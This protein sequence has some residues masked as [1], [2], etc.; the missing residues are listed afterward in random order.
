VCSTGVIT[1]LFTRK[2]GWQYGSHW[3]RGRSWWSSVLVTLIVIHVTVTTKYTSG[4]LGKSV[5]EQ[6]LITQTVS[7][8]FG[9]QVRRIL[10]EYIFSEMSASVQWVHVYMKYTLYTDPEQTIAQSRFLTCNNPLFAQSYKYSVRALMLPCNNP[11]SSDLLNRRDQNP[12]DA[13]SSQ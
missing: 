6:V 8:F 12:T 5:A 3:P 4:W 9:D 2:L 1:V 7:L 11:G 10:V 13:A